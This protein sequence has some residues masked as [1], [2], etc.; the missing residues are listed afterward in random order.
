MVFAQSTVAA[1]LILVVLC[2]PPLV[3]SALFLMF[4]P[5]WLRSQVARAPVML[6]DLVRMALRG[7][8]YRAVAR[9][10]IEAGQAGILIPTAEIEKACRDGVDLDKV[11]RAVIQA[12]ETGFELAF[13]DLVATELEER[14]ADLVPAGEG[15]VAK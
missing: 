14:Q 2:L 11:T 9:C 5:L 3:C 12:R 4:F 7:T 1:V 15:V 13:Q 10:R 6:V 8:D